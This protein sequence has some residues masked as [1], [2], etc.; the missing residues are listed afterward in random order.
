MC[1][2]D[3]STQAPGMVR[4][5][6]TVDDDEKSARPKTVVCKKC[7]AE[8]EHKTYDCPVIIVSMSLWSQWDRCLHL[9]MAIVVLNMWCPG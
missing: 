8:G 4:Y 6:E 7:G 9:L 3:E 1:A 5:F 2:V